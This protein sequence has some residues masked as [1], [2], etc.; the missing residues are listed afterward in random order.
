MKRFILAAIAVVL[1]LASCEKDPMNAILGTWEAEKIHMNIEGLEMSMD[2]AEMTGGSL[3]M[4]FEKNGNVTMTESIEGESYS[5]TFNFTYADNTLTL[6]YEGDS[7]SIPVTIAGDVLTMKVTPE[8]MDEEEFDGEI[9][10]TFR[11]K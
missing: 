7:V 3:E 11:R 8:I 1:G 6:T 4:T 9:E 10:I 5:E 2:I